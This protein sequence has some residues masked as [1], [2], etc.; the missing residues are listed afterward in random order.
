MASICCWGGHEAERAVRLGTVDPMNL[1]RLVP[2]EGSSDDTRF[3]HSK[4]GIRYVE[5]ASS[6]VSSL[7]RGFLYALDLLSSSHTGGFEMICEEV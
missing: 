1:I 7:R 3:A 5:S 6:R 4:R 2:A